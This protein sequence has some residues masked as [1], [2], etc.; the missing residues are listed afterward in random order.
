MEKNVSD[1]K[2]SRLQRMFLFNFILRKV[3]NRFI[4]EPA[5]QGY[6]GLAKGQPILFSSLNLSIPTLK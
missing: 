2:S 4:T 5:L 1:L 3:E 6:M